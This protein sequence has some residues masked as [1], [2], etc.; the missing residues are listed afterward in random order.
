MW[1]FFTRQHGALEGRTAQET[2]Q[3][4]LDGLPEVRRLA[5]AWVRENEGDQA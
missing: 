1:V 2:L 5:R 3:Q 4:D